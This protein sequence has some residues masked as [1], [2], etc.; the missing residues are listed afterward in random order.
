MSAWLA[1]RASAT[2]T[3]RSV[4]D[5]N[6]CR[7]FLPLQSKCHDLADDDYA[8]AV[9]SPINVAAMAMHE[10]KD[11]KITV[12]SAHLTISMLHGPHNHAIWKA[13]LLA[14]L[15]AE[16]EQM[17]AAATGALRIDGTPT[18]EEEENAR[19]KRSHARCIPFITSTLPDS[20]YAMV[21]NYNT[22]ASKLMEAL[23]A[24][25]RPYPRYSAA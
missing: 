2:F 9:A 23:D 18:E 22:D 8:K 5:S 13:R 4:G 10:P 3:A 11:D 17:Y 20:I 1:R 14:A 12:G 25:F 21:M 7:R 19:R 24:R 6:G 16:D 15:N